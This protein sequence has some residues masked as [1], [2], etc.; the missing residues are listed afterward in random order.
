MEIKKKVKKIAN[1]PEESPEREKE[2]LLSNIPNSLARD[3]VQGVYFGVSLN[4]FHYPT[5]LF[6]IANSTRPMFQYGI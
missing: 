1:Q 3:F 5:Y 4:I 6:L 2:C